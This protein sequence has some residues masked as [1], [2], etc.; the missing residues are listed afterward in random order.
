MLVQRRSATAP[1]G[2]DLMCTYDALW[3]AWSYLAMT[4]PHGQ[5]P[6]T[7]FFRVPID[8]ADA[9]RRWRP[10]RPDDVSMWVDAA[11]VAA[12]L[13]RGSR[14]SRALTWAAP[15]TCTTSGVLPRSGISASEDAGARTSRRSTS[16]CQRRRTAPS[17]APSATRRGPTSNQC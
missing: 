11:A 3:S 13:P 15:P 10:L 7:L 5:W 8:A 17:R 9:P 14:K 16:G 6:T 12:G 1:P 2:S 4:V